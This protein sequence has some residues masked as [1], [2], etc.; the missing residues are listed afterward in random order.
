MAKTIT[1]ICAVRGRKK[2]LVSSLPFPGS[3]IA[4]AERRIATRLLKEAL[5]EV[6]LSEL[7]SFLD[8]LNLV[9]NDVFN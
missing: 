9:Q 8:G 3:N 1:N 6:S 5:I 7:H 2:D 4:I